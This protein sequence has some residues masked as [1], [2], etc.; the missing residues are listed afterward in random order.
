MN[1]VVVIASKRVL[2]SVTASE[3]QGEEPSV[4]MLLKQ[5]IEECRCLKRSITSIRVLG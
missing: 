3:D 4:E 2:A 1:S 5:A